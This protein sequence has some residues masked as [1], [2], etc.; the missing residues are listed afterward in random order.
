M[1]DDAKRAV[2]EIARDLDDLT[3]RV[4]EL[5]VDPTTDEHAKELGRLRMAL[6]DAGDAADEVE[7]NMDEAE[8][9]EAP[10]D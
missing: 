7:E 9:E 8:G 4:E 3:T 2:D 1:A 5:E 6:E 10:N